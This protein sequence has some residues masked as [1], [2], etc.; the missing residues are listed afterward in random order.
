MNTNTWMIINNIGNYIENII[1][2]D[3]DV[4]K[5]TPPQGTSAVKIEDVDFSTINDN[6]DNPEINEFVKLKKYGHTII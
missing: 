2:W 5:W 4:N 1:V 6:P 3:G